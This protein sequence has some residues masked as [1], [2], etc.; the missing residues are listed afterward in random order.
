M[1][2]PVLFLHAKR[3]A[4]RS[5][6]LHLKKGCSMGERGLLEKNQREERRGV[7]RR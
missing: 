1:T 5:K 2:N 6:G 7:R 4:F 3:I